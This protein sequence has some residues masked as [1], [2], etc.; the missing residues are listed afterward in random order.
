MR[1][2]GDIW[3]DTSAYAKMPVYATERT[4]REIQSFVK[5]GWVRS[6][7]GSVQ[8]EGLL[9][10]NRATERQLCATERRQPSRCVKQH[11]LNRPTFG[12]R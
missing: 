4:P 5:G 3:R 7:V 11:L 10:R 6:K 2:A 1:A 12:S 9:R 8:L